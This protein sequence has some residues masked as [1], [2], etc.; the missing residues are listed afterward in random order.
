[1]ATFGSKY[2]LGAATTVHHVEQRS[3]E[4]LEL[5]KMRVTGSNVAA[6]SGRSFLKTPNMLAVEMRSNSRPTAPNE[7][8]LRGT[9][10]E[11]EA[12]EVYKRRVRPVRV[13]HYGFVTSRLHPDL[14]YSPDGVA[15]FTGQSSPGNIPSE[16]PRLL[17]IKCPSKATYALRNEHY[18]Q[19]QMGMELLDLES[20]DLAI[21]NPDAD[22]VD[23]TGS[24]CELEMK[25]ISIAN[26]PHMLVL[27]VPRDRRHWKLLSSLVDDFFNGFMR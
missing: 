1:M 3:E 21:Y 2:G 15:W 13:C 18:D 25:K 11:P 17:E 14:G 27:T 19:V 5:R 12:E 8:M 20:C 9:R 10:L 26:Y 6:A 22:S 23:F 7:H 24:R 16:T 4:W